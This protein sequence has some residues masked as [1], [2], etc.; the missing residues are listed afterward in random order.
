LDAA[1]FGL[2][3]RRCQEAALQLPSLESELASI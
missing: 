2:G 3:Q 1:G